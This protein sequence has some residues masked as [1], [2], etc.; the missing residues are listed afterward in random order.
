MGALV[1]NLRPLNILE[2]GSGL[3]TIFLSDL[4]SKQGNGH[5]FTVEDSSEYLS[6]TKE[7]TNNATNLSLFLSPISRYVFKGKLCHTYLQD[8]VLKLPEVHFDI[9]LIDGPLAYKYGRE[10]SLYL[11]TPFLKSETLILLDDS[12]REPEQKAIANWRRAWSRNLEVIQFRDLKKGFSI[13]RIN[14][15]SHSN[16]Y[17]FPLVEIARSYLPFSRF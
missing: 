14:D 1:N 6:K 8:F 15:P 4:L 16:R 9:V 2:F 12:N 11:I 17:P 5:L 10:A 3:S 7:M 13:I